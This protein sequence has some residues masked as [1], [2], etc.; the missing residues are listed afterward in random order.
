LAQVNGSKAPAKLACQIVRKLFDEGFSILS[1]FLT[2]L[3]KLDDLTPDFPIYGLVTR[4]GLHGP[5]LLPL[6]KPRSAQWP[7]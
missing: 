1:P 6:C 5:M 3:L 7:P 4:T 2:L